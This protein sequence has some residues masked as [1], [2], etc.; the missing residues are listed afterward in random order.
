M[1]KYVENNMKVYEEI[2]GKCEKIPPT[3]L[4]TLKL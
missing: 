4:Y 3:I 2:R 1:K